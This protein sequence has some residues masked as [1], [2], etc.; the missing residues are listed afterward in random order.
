MSKNKYILAIDTTG[1]VLSVSLGK[2]TQDNDPSSIQLL[3][4]LAINKGNSHDEMLA[5]S[6]ST[7][8]S[9]WSIEIGDLAAVLVSNGPGA[10]TG[11][12]IGLSFAKGLAMPFEIPLYTFDTLE[13]A[14]YSV[15]YR[16]HDWDNM[17]LIIRRSHADNYYANIDGQTCYLNFK[18]LKEKIGILSQDSDVNILSE[19][20][21]PDMK[22]EIIS[23]RA[24]NL[25]NAFKYGNDSNYSISQAGIDA[26]PNYKQAFIPTTSNKKV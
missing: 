21:I 7:L 8:M 24:N 3:A 9:L 19:E 2:Y 11:L 25:L 4:D 1:S 12:R 18:Q 16:Y 17:P 23:F 5:D 6:V 20:P 14:R 22:S 15:S 10:F 13:A 26:V